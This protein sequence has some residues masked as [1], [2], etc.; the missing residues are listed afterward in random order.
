MRGS[1][2]QPSVGVAVAVVALGVVLAGAATPAAA[3][4]D[5]ESPAVTLSSADVRVDGGEE[6]TVTATYEFAVESPGSGDAALTAIS[7]TMWRFEGREI[8]DVTATVDGSE[9]SPEVTRERRFVSLSVPVE[10]VSAGDTVTVELTYTV[11][12]PAGEL[13]VPLWSPEF[14]TTG[15]SRVV[16]LTTTLPEGTQ[17]QGANFPSVDDRDGNV[18]SSQMAHVPG[19]VSVS[20]GSGSGPLFSLDVVSTLVGLVIIFGFF[21]VWAAWT[22]GYIGDG[23]E[24]DVA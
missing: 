21:G 8:G 23:G 5:G 24:P 4:Q 14:Q 16:S 3:Q 17:P 19:F 13:K 1:N 7:G 2:W 15:E 6:S 11:T 22:R 9:V 18:L 12:G 20:Y 10:D